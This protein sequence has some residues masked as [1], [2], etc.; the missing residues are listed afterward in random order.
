MFIIDL[1]LPSFLPIVGTSS[2]FDWFTSMDVINTD[3]NFHS[4]CFPAKDTSKEPHY[5]DLQRKLSEPT[6]LDCFTPPP[7]NKVNADCTPANIEHLDKLIDLLPRHVIEQGRFIVSLREPVTRAY[8]WY[9]HAV[10][11]CVR[12]RAI[13][14][15]H[16]F[17]CKS[18]YYD[19]DRRKPFTDSEFLDESMHRGKSIEFT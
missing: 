8:S 19:L 7:P 17:F 15:R 11:Q 5:F 10:C 14:Q 12:L 18:S 9:K 13:G 2:L 3:V 4:K 16:N 1:R 6:Y